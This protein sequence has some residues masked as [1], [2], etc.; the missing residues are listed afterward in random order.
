MANRTDKNYQSGSQET[1][2][3]S[4][5][6]QSHC[7]ACRKDF[8]ID[9]FRSGGKGGQHQNK[10]DTGVRI[11]H[12]PSGLS[13]ECRD[14]RSQITNQR[15]AFNKLAPK[16]ENWWR[17]QQKFAEIEA[18][19]V[20]E[21]IRTYNQAKNRIT[22]HATGKKYPFDLDNPKFILDRWKTNSQQ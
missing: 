9:K 10:T 2:R 20:T 13:A 16:V 15:K 18:I 17:Q 19:Q 3:Y 11:T 21:T 4:K 5:C 22:D 7:I 14:T 12:I 8:R 1:R 6:G